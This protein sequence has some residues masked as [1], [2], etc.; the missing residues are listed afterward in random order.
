MLLDGFGRPTVPIT[1]AQVWLVA[2]FAD[3]QN[4][5]PSLRPQDIDVNGQDGG[6]VAVGY[7]GSPSPG[8]TTPSDS[9][10]SSTAKGCGI[11]IAILILI[12]VVQAF[13]QCVGQ[14]ANKHTC[15]FWDN[16]LLKK[17]WEQDPPDPHDPTHPE[18][19]NVTAAQLTAVA[20]SPQA[21]QLVGMLFDIHCQVWE[22]MDRAYAFLAV[23]GLIYPGDL[24]TMPLYAQFTALP[25]K[26]LWPHREE[27]DPT[28][29][30]HLYP[31][32]PLENP[33]TDPSPF[34]TGAH[35]N[36]SLRQG[37]QLSLGL[38]RQIAAGEF[39][40]Q[41]RDLDADRSF[42]HP[43]WTAGGSIHD[44]P[45]DVVILDYNEQ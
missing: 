29:L 21:A 30:Y 27:A 32:S 6:G 4:P 19:P 23:T 5:P 2:L 44:D 11:V 31:N 40:S 38:W 37:E 45:V 41:N 24:I 16:M 13:V 15:T 33:T 39:D 34:P 35:P 10:S 20:S 8:S 22:A 42:F 36:I 26:L 28:A 17:A 7:G 18:N 14:W 43:C 25:G 9:D 1:P 12:D 3:T